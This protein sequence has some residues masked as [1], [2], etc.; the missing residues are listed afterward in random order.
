MEKNGVYTKDILAIA[1]I[2]R[3]SEE[4]PRSQ[5]ATNLIGDFRSRHKRSPLFFASE[6][7][8]KSDG[9][10]SERASEV[11]ISFYDAVESA[12]DESNLAKMLLYAYAIDDESLWPEQLKQKIEKRFTFFSEQLNSYLNEEQENLEK[13]VE[14]R[15][16]LSSQRLGYRTANNK[17]LTKA[18]SLESEISRTRVRN[19]NTV[20]ILD[21]LAKIRNGLEL[22]TSNLDLAAINYQRLGL[23]PSFIEFAEREYR[24]FETQLASGQS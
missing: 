13:L 17:F 21:A 14:L 7:S 2:R 20:I 10:F 22:S 11:L 15:D 8:K 23:N 12:I 18:R 6:L 5:T 9:L 4:I 16:E 1:L 24:E 3:I 19:R